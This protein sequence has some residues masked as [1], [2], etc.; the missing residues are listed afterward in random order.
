M[1]GFAFTQ[2]PKGIQIMNTG[3]FI[4]WLTLTGFCI[5]YR[6]KYGGL[7]YQGMMML[8][9]NEAFPKSGRL[10]ILFISL[11][12]PRNGSDLGFINFANQYL[13]NHI[14]KCLG[15]KFLLIFLQNLLGV[16]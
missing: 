4:L 8:D 6:D 14:Q 10:I 2:C 5:D 16:D 11:T 3:S 9:V 7:Y 13:Y 15:A 12:Y 1:P